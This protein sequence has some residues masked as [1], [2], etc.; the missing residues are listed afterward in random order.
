MRHTEKLIRQ[1]QRNLEVYIL[2]TAKADPKEF[3]SCVRKKKVLSSTI[4]PLSLQNGQLESDEENMAD[5]LN[6]YFDSGFTEQKKI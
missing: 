3:Y 2:S 4:G 1:N 5:L 6:E